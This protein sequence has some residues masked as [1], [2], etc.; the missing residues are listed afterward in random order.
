MTAKEETNIVNAIDMPEV[1]ITMKA[2]GIV[3]VYFKNNCV[4][5]TVLQLKLLENYLIVTDNKPAPFVFL[6]GDN[7]TIT[8]EARDNATS[9]EDKSP[10]MASA[11]IVNNLAYKLIANFY[12]QFNKPKRPYKVFTA[13]ED[14]E[15][16]LK[17]FLKNS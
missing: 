12:L 10:C 2:N 9:L 8:R 16:W 6:A 11:V 4:L 5:D 1:S 17:Q 14:G 13:I 3:Y 7:V 15:L